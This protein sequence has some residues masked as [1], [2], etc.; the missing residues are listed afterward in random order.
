MGRVVA[1]KPAS[2]PRSAT[3]VPVALG[4]HRF[5]LRSVPLQGGS[6]DLAL[7][8]STRNLDE[9][10]QCFSANPVRHTTDNLVSE[11]DW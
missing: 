6:C 10:F 4:R 8:G 7:S 11:L 1:E 5:W 3:V 2:Q 9:W